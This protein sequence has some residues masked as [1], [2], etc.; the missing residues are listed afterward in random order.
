MASLRQKTDVKPIHSRSLDLKTYPLEEDRI[1]V[2]GWL[3]DE[4]FKRGYG[5]DGQVRK[6]GLVH[7]MAVR[8]LVGGM[9]PTILDAEAE[10]GHVPHELCYSTQDSIKKVIGLAIKSGFGEIVHKMIGGVEGCA[11]LAHLVMV[12]GQ[13]AV[14][15]YWTHKLAGQPPAPR[16]LEG[17]ESLSYVI[18]SCFLWREDGPLH[19]EIE[20]SLRTSANRGEN[21]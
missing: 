10:M 9:P 4:R 5:L 8:L 16:P 15:G 11:H 13:E 3:K 19:R 20:A 2:E 6:E 7:H 12:M 17:I 21:E 14:H 1:I 18:N